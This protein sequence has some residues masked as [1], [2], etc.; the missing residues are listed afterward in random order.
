MTFHRK[1]PS[2]T[3]YYNFIYMKDRAVCWIF[4][5]PQIHM[6]KPNIKCD[7]MWQWG[8]WELI[9]SWGW[10]PHGISML[11]KETPESFLAP[12]TLWGHSKRM[13]VNEQRSRLSPDTEP[14]STLICGLLNSRT[15]R[16]KCLVFKPPIQ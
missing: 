13:P 12:S 8:L 14:L 7:D 3:K 15:V 16:N 5:F 2:F 10:S 4:V 9:R 11:I 6:L 1:G